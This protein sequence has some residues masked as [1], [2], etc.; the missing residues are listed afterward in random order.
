MQWQLRRYTV[1]DFDAF[2]HEWREHVLPLRR[3]HG[4]EVL[5]PWRDEDGRFVWIAGHA[6]FAAADERYYESDER[7][8]IDPD[9][10]R[11]VAAAENVA[12][13]DA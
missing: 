9:P 1:H 7:R 13:D 10:A 4:F 2:A 5:G 12:M 11:H 3:A 6:D 8:A